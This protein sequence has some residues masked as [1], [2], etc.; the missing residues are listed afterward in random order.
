M[1]R[2][3]VRIFALTALIALV[4]AAGFLLWRRSQMLLKTGDV[5]FVFEPHVRTLQITGKRPVVAATVTG[6]LYLLSV[7][8]TGTAPALT[9]RMSHDGGDHWMPPTQLSSPDATVTTSSEN[10][11]QLAARGMY[12]FALWQEKNDTTGPQ[13]RLARSSGMDGKPPLSTL[14]T[15]KPANDKSYS[16]FAVVRDR[17]KRRC[18][19][20]LARRT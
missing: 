5:A 8:K 3:F 2:K 13:L 10:A 12:A 1:T 17:T 16:G 6:G 18:L 14:V 9:L 7:E 11:P 20:R 19:R 4:L 15:D